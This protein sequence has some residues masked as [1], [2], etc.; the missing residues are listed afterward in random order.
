MGYNVEPFR[1]GSNHFVWSGVWRSQQSGMSEGIEFETLTVQAGKHSDII[2]RISLFIDLKLSNLLQHFPLI[3][4][5]KEAD[6]SH[7]IRK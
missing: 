5:I 6:S 1:G 4:I 3:V 7:R 2:C